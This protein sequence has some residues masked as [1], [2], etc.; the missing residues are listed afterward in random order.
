MSL[1]SEN[2]K[3]VWSNEVQ[4]KNSNPRL[5]RSPSPAKGIK[6]KI[7]KRNPTQFINEM[8]NKKTHKLPNFDKLLKKVLVYFP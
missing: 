7:R 8:V 5:K 3:N 6:T 2:K 1:S 4:K